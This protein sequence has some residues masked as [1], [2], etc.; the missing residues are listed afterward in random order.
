ML[1]RAFRAV[2]ARAQINATHY[3]IAWF[4]IGKCANTG[5]NFTWRIQMTAVVP[6]SVSKLPTKQA[7]V[8]Q[9]LAELSVPGKYLVTFLFPVLRQVYAYR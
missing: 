1:L 4:E 5:T 8:L 9:E 2:Y 3:F 7:G 6:G